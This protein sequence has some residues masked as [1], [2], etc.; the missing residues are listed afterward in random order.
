MAWAAGAVNENKLVC[1]T[2][3]GIVITAVEEAV[4]VPKLAEMY[5]T[6]DSGGS[7]NV[8]ENDENLIGAVLTTTTVV[9]MTVAVAVVLGLK[10]QNAGVH[11]SKHKK[12]F[13]LR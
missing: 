13:E 4:A 9:V 6:A 1:D 11:M 3:F 5:G 12:Y 8:C 10:W 7:Q 2:Y